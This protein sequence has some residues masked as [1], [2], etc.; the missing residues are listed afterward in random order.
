M[1]FCRR[2]TANQIDHVLIS[3]KFRSAITD[4]KTLRGPDIGSDHNLLKTNFKVILRGKTGN[5][6]NQKRKMT[7]IF[8][9]SKW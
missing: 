8:Q 6:Y 4:I 3:N 9:N 7:N 5:K 2:Q 1:V